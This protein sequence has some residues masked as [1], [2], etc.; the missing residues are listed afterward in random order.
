MACGESRPWLLYELPAGLIS[1]YRIAEELDLTRTDMEGGTTRQRREHTRRNAMVAVAFPATT[2]DLQTMAA[3]I[4]AYGYDGLE[5]PLIT[6]ESGADYVEMRACRFTEGYT[7]T[8][9]SRGM[10]ELASMLL[11]EGLDEAC[12]ADFELA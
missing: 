3:V 6:G 5:I 7:V 11:V 4:E 10:W 8:A 9:R 12:A 2:A 1:G